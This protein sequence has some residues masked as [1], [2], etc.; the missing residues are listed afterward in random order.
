V[1]GKRQDP[2]S[3]Y[4]GVISKFIEKLIKNE[5]LMIF[6]DG[7]QSRDFVHVEDVAR[8]NWLALQGTVTGAIN[9]ASGE[10]QTLNQ[11]VGYLE[12]IGGQAMKVDYVE[13]RMGDIPRSYANTQKAQDLLQFKAQIPLLEGLKSVMG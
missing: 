8:A 1:Y 11:L 2:H 5:P 10:P 9:I 13:K 3:P 6:G 4:S 12:K 7:E